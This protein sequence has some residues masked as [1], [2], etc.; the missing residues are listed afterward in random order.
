MLVTC[1]HSI[2]Y[3]AFVDDLHR[4]S[5]Y[6][7]FWFLLSIHDQQQFIA[8]HIDCNPKKS[9][10]RKLIPEEV[11]QDFTVLMPLWMSLTIILETHWQEHGGN[12]AEGK[13]GKHTPQNKLICECHQFLQHHIL[14]VSSVECINV[15]SLAWKVHTATVEHYTQSAKEEFCRSRKENICFRQIQISFQWNQPWWFLMKKDQ[16]QKCLVLKSMT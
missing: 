12:G 15:I 7:K 10:R 11:T 6:S 2:H 8:N 4:W 1:I 13:T 16:W 5:F 3:C 9:K 14:W